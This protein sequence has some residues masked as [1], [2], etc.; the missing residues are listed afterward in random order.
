A[1]LTQL[2]P[3]ILKS[4]PAQALLQPLETPGHAAV[5]DQVAAAAYDTTDDL[6]PHHVADPHLLARLGPQA[7]PQA[8]HLFLCSLVGGLPLDLASSPHRIRFPPQ[9]R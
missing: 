4:G 5:H 2:S 6:G 1:G 7:L 9:L 3:H 8:L